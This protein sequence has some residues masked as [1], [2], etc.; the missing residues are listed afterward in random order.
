MNTKILKQ[1]L[2]AELLNNE[3]WKTVKLGEVCE[4]NPKNIID[5]DTDVSF[6]PM[7]LISGDF[8]NKHTSEIRKWKDVKKGFTHFKEGDIGIA[9]ITPCFENRK[10]VIFRDLENNFGAGTTELHILR[11]KIPEILVNFIFWTIKTDDFIKNGIKNFNGAVGQQRV[12]KNIIENYVIHLPPLAVQRQI[13]ARIEEIFVEINR[14]EQSR[15][16]LLQAVKTAKQKVLTELLNNDEWKIGKLG[17]VGHW[18]AGTTPSRTNKA[19]YEN[20]TIPWLKTGDLNDGFVSEV[21]EKIS[22]LAIQELKQL[23]LHPKGSVAIALY[24]ATIGKCG[25]LDIETTTN[26]A[27]LVCRH[28]ELIYNKYLFYF[29]ISKNDYF[30]KVAGGGAQPNISKDI[31][32]K[33]NIPIPPISIQKVVVEQI[34]R[35]FAEIEKIERAIKN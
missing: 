30:K 35:F 12:G 19:Y 4:V 15:E 34:E 5:D 25:I 32:V 6:I 16:R 1:K 33:T 21:P 23:K 3:E 13:V 10:S 27:C 28:N 26:Q 17:E 22:K 8:A 2:L 18:Q 29:L 14:I 24:G 7:T 11:P 9:K 31:V 20:G